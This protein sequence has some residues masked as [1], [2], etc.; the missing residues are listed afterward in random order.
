MI[1]TNPIIGLTKQQ[2]PRRY[3]DGQAAQHREYNLVR[4]KIDENRE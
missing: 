1:E 4:K 2:T 3:G